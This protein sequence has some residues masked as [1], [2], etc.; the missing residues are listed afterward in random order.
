MVLVDLMESGK[1]DGAD[2]DG[3]GGK[4]ISRSG[5]ISVGIACPK[6]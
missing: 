1:K 2:G 3:D 6:M 4:D 5:M